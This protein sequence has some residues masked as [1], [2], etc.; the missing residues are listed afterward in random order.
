M[1]NALGDEVAR[2]SPYRN[3]LRKPDRERFDRMMHSA[4]HPAPSIELPERPFQVLLLLVLM[5]Q[6]DRLV[7]LE[8]GIAGE[9]EARM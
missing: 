3:A 1:A 6:H 4:L 7:E 2:W 8:R 5:Y 9:L